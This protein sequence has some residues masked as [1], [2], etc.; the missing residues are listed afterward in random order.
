MGHVFLCHPLCHQS[1]FV[2]SWDKP[3]RRAIG[4][5]A[6][7]ATERTADG[8]Y[9]QNV[10]RHSLDGLYASMIKQKKKR[11]CGGQGASAAPRAAR[12]VRRRRG[13]LIQT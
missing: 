7:S 12:R 10:R 6:T 11:Q 2:F 4:E 8:K 9:G 13:K 5:L 1:S 3:G